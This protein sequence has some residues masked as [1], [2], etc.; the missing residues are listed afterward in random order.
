MN[1]VSETTGKSLAG[2]V[3]DVLLRL[4]LQR[5]GLRGQTY[6]GATHFA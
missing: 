1:Y 2:V 4:K 5:H 6:D 3:K